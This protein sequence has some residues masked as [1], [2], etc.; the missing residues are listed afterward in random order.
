[1]SYRTAEN[2]GAEELCDDDDAT[3][4]LRRFTAHARTSLDLFMK[5]QKIARHNTTVVTTSSRRSRRHGQSSNVRGG[6]IIWHKLI[7]SSET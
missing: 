1:M 6:L 7:R 4:G 2:H 3:F 5:R